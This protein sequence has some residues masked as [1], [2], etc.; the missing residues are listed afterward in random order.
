MIKAQQASIKAFPDDLPNGGATM[1]QSA[2][3]EVYIQGYEQ[4]EKD[5]ALIPE[6]MGV[7]FNLV[8]KLQYKYGDVRGCYDEAL[9]LFNKARNEGTKG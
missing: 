9:K 2:R 3:R 8:R 1:K 4:A 6:D 5:L 7:I